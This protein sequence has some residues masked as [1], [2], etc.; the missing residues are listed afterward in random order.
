MQDWREEVSTDDHDRERPLDLG[1]DAIGK[2]SGKEPHAGRDAC[3]HDRA[4]TRLARIDESI[5]S[6]KP[7][8][9]API[10]I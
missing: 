10:K 6:A 5:F 7:G 8:F 2:G 9:E 1:A 3:H 4:K